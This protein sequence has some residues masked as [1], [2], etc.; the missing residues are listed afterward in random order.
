MPKPVPGRDF[1][2]VP[3]D[4]I[5]AGRTTDLYFV[6]TLDILKK[7]GRSRANVV[8][9]VTTG[10]LPNDWPWGIFCGLE[11]VV[12]LLEGKGVSLWALPEGSVFPPKTH[13]GIPLPVMILEGPY[14]EWALYETPVLGMI[15]QASGIATK[16]A[17]IRK[18]AN[19]KQV[20]SFGVRRMHPGIAPLIERSVTIGGLPAIGTMPHA[21][22]IVMGGPREAF[23]AV[24][25]YLE[26]KIPRIALVDTYYDEKTEALL[27]VEA[28]PDLA[29]IRLD[30]P[31]SRRGNLPAIVREVR[32]E[33]DLRG[34]K[35]VKIFVSGAVDEKSIPALL[36]AGVD[37]FGI[38]TSLSN[39]PTIDFAL[40]LVEVDGKPA[41][42]RGKFGGRKDLARCPKDGTYDVGV[43]TCPVCGTK[44]APAYTQYLEHGRVTAPF[45]ALDAIRERAM[46][47]TERVS[48]EA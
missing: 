12:H 33:L 47:E 41:A 26:A 5:R 20:L 28:I 23:A 42:K 27:A 3:A 39:A 6:R 2:S 37:G 29:G 15:C 38:G 16:A 36:E 19:G 8:A 40:D 13:R 34:H 17:R 25:K 32:W 4:E 14:E 46:R 10:A 21:L 24:H 35:D 48:L 18:L 44:M 7:A 9:E 43:R 30:T 22:V 11:E 31:A 1:D 45:P